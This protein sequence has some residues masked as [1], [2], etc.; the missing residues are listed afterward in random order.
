ML[1]NIDMLS[2]LVLKTQPV[3]AQYHITNLSP[4]RQHA[5]KRA[6]KS[7]STWLSAIHHFDLTPNEFRYG[8]AIKYLK[9]PVD[10]PS[11]CDG[12]GVYFTLQHGLDCKKSGLV[13]QR[14]NEVQAAW[15]T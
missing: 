2:E 14:Q 5:L 11:R 9:L 6:A 12:C 1:Q 7:S 8:L 10:L 4:E 15:E 3:Q 13:I